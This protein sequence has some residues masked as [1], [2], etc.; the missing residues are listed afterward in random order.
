MPGRFHHMTVAAYVIKSR[1]CIVQN[2][3]EYVCVAIYRFETTIVA[4][5]KSR[6]RYKSTSQC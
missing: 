2:S 1:G 3:C 4:S 6:I 5:F